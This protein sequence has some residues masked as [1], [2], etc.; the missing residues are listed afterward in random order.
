MWDI[1]IAGR[2][3][4]LS[5]GDGLCSEAPW[6]GFAFTSKEQAIL[7]IFGSGSGACGVGAGDITRNEYHDVSL[8]FDDF[9]PVSPANQL[10]RSAWPR[11]RRR[12]SARRLFASTWTR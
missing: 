4:N 1:W 10:H 7:S 2:D 11:L 6:D 9:Y 12:L 3:R 8:H 5:V